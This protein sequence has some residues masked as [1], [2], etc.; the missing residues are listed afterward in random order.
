MV[1]IPELVIGVVLAA[2]WVVPVA[3]AVWAL[4]TLY[5]IRNSQ[6]ALGARLETIER[7]L[8]TSRQPG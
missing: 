3:A 2:L 1:G 6:E 7:L 8:H 5:R 4:L